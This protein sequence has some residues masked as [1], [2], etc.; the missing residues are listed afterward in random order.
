MIVNTLMDRPMNAYQLAVALSLNYRTIV[1]HL[2]ILEENRIVRSEGPRYGRIF[3][4]TSLLTENIQIY[5]KI[6]NTKL[7]AS[8]G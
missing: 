1:H 8:G 4:P 6:T 2:E 5:K 7:G 3:F